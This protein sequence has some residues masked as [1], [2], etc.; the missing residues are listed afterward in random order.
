MYVTKHWIDYFVLQVQGCKTVMLDCGQIFA[1]MQNVGSKH[2]GFFI[3][4]VSPF[5]FKLSGVTWNHWLSL[6][7][8]CSHKWYPSENVY[9]LWKENVSPYHVTRVWRQI[10]KFILDPFE[11]IFFGTNQIA[12]RNIRTISSSCR[13]MHGHPLK[14]LHANSDIH[15][16]KLTVNMFIILGY[17]K[18]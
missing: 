1:F 9:M 2:A 17:V 5:M 15:K 7:D 11:N 18:H 6:N 16:T 8:G 3:C 13:F 10:M 12:F 14:H 4:F